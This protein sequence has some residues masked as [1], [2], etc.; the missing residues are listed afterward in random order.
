[1]RSRIVVLA[2]LITMVGLFSTGCFTH[3]YNVGRGAPN[4][5]VVY[6]KW[7]HHWLFA[8][9][10]PK[11]D[12]DIKQ[13]CPSGDATIVDKHTFIN[14]LLGAFGSFIWSPTT[15]TIRCAGGT[16]GEVEVEIDEEVARRIVTDPLFELLVAEVAPERLPELQMALARIGSETLSTSSRVGTQRRD[17]SE[18][19]TAASP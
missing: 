8:L 14:Q 3:S 17:D 10:S 12:L 11:T 16:T 1:V 15:V 13:F 2:A 18:N 19:G 4:G 6:K 7:H 9:I 5:E